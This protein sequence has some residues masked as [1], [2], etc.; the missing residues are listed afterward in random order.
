VSPDPKNHFLVSRSQALVM[1]GGLGCAA[2]ALVL[3]AW[4]AGEVREGEMRPFDSRVRTLIYQPNSPNLTRLM[5]KITI[6]GSGELLV[7]LASGLVL[8]FLIAR[9]RHH[10][11]LVVVTLSGA[12]LL[13][14][15]LKIH[16]KIPRP[17]CA[18]IPVPES[19]SFPSGHALTSLCFYGLLASFITGSMRNQ[20]A[21]VSTWF[22]AVLLVAA[23]GISR[24]YLC[25]H[26]A[27]DVL[28]GYA[29]A[30][31][32]IVAVIAGDHLS[33]RRARLRATR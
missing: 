27:S 3:F 20:A 5:M 25:L 28:A 13:G 12:G 33:W 14:W 30:L 22:I 31:V 8:A 16:F 9:W 1:A 10:A 2:A 23:I 7:P 17:T 21:I 15:L 11:L 19:Y 32:W 6:L 18:T 24:I 29:A 4:L 26:N